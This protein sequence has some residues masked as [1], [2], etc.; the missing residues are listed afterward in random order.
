ML[1]DLGNH[2]HRTRLYAPGPVGR[3]MLR[4]GWTG[5]NTY[6]YILLPAVY[7]AGMCLASQGKEEAL[8]CIEAIKQ[9]AIS[10]GSVLCLAEDIEQLLL[11]NMAAGD[12]GVPAGETEAPPTIPHLPPT[13]A[14]VSQVLTV[15]R[16]QPLRHSD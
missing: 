13:S 7:E 9:N 16:V 4:A 12:S 3:R 2:P 6:R 5:G 8:A 10:Y 15:P 11:A 14:Q 1:I